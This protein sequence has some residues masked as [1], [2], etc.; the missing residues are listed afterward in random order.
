MW[1]SWI[2]HFENEWKW[3]IWKVEWREIFKLCKTIEY[4]RWKNG[5]MVVKY[6]EETW[7]KKEMEK[8]KWRELKENKP[9]NTSDGREVRE[10]KTKVDGGRREMKGEIE[11]EV[12][13]EEREWRLSSPLKVSDSIETRLKKW[14]LQKRWKGV[15]EEMN[16]G[17]NE[18]KEE[19]WIEIW[20]P[21]KAFF[22]KTQRPLF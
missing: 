6:E 10:L 5:N 21:K 1:E 19:E 7:K 4:S 14:N 22:L 18:E 11:D 13:K 9:S 2:P 8:K 20:R 17:E 12:V 15:K 3:K 16:G